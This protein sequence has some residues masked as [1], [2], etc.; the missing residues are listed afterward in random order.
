MQALRASLE[1]IKQI[2]EGVHD[3]LVAS[4]KN[5]EEMAG[6]NTI[7]PLVT[8]SSHSRKME[9]INR[10]GGTRTQNPIS[11]EPMTLSHHGTNA[12]IRTV[13]QVS[14]ISC[15]SVFFTLRP[16]LRLPLVQT[17]NKSMSYS[18]HADARLRMTVIMLT[19]SG[20]KWRKP[21]NDGGAR[22]SY[23]IKFCVHISFVITLRF[24]YWL[25]PAARII[26]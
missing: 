2:V 15:I 13:E 8:N 23:S 1:S 11:N 21:S 16:L 7:S 3:D 12:R 18:K 5:Y 4:Q 14:W 17:C 25:Y 26:E 22:S 20:N 24:P 9:S 19:F 10:S 6:I